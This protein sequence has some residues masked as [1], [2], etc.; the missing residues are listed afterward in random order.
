MTPQDYFNICDIAHKSGFITKEQQQ[1][2]LHV[3]QQFIQQKKEVPIVAI[4]KKYGL[5]DAQFKSIQQQKERLFRQTVVSKQT[6]QQQQKDKELE[7]SFSQ[8]ISPVESNKRIGKYSVIKLLGSGAMGSVYLV[9]D[10][11]G[12]NFALKTMLPAVAETKVGLK[13]FQQEVNAMKMLRHA[14]I[15]KI[16]EIGQQGNTHYFTMEYIEGKPLSDYVQD[17]MSAK[18]IAYIIE[19][20]AR[21]LD[22]AHS[23]NII[24]RDIKPANIMI[25]KSGEPIIMDFGLARQSQS[26]NR[27]TKT[28][29]MLGTLAYMPP[30]Q[31][32]GN[33]REID[34]QT[35][36]YALGASMY[37][38]MTR[39][40]PFSGQHLVVL[41][42][43]VQDEP[44]S[45]RELNNLIPEALE[46]ICLKAMAKKKEFRFA[47][48]MEMAEDLNRF[49]GG[50]TIE[51][52]LDKATLSKKGK[53]QI[54]R[55]ATAATC[56][57][58]ILAIA[59]L[60]SGQ[61]S[62]R[63]DQEKIET[64]EKQLEAWNERLRRD[65]KNQKKKEAEKKKEFDL[66]LKKATIEA[67]K[68]IIYNLINPLVNYIKNNNVRSVLK[69]LKILIFFREHWDTRSLN[70]IDEATRFIITES[71]LEENLFLKVDLAKTARE[72]AMF[73]V[74]IASEEQ[75]KVKFMEH[76]LQICYNYT[77]VDRE[78]A[79]GDFRKEWIK[80]AN[81]TSIYQLHKIKR[82]IKHNFKSVTEQ[83]IEAYPE[84]SYK[85]YVLADY[86]D[87][88][89]GNDNRKRSIA[90]MEKALEL[91]INQPEYIQE[92][93]KYY[94]K[95]HGYSD[96]QTKKEIEKKSRNFIKKGLEVYQAFL[97]LSPNSLRDI[98]EKILKEK[99]HYD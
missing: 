28:G 95:L 66:Q 8:T 47:S 32:K 98:K 60:F 14:N 42:K 2:I 59:M 51:A 70:I 85:Y 37:E 23:K 87:G 63:K 56:I 27:L 5:Q 68:T 22:Y 35:D 80:L 38:L 43:I 30:E 57:V 67:N 90:L 77:P 39:Q 96:E 73:A 44:T 86:Y 79:L 9:K 6:Q 83:E 15:I 4:L 93:A 16:F 50:E 33:K 1:E 49:L 91:N 61:K 88:K 75:Q 41:R 7:L 40:L 46:R 10:D 81:K 21:A 76:F 29:A 89:I 12:K 19:K 34:H 53:V 55:F 13:R 92:I 74:E 84:S 82:R 54:L 31:V 18:K 64:L 94:K 78:K 71:Y 69:H 99:V 20:V 58:A 45:P 25:S 65:R 24:H 62:S 26:D 36:I 17:K 72:V 11:D 48:A 3:V 52:K 97:E